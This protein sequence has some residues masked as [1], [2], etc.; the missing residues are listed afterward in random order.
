M[1]GL[2]EPCSVPSCPVVSSGIM[3]VDALTLETG[4]KV[5]VLS[6]V[7]RALWHPIAWHPV[8]SAYITVGPWHVPSNSH[9]PY[10]GGLLPWTYVYWWR[11][12]VH[13]EE[14]RPMGMC[15]FEDNNVLYL[16]S[17]S[18]PFSSRYVFVLQCSHVCPSGSDCS[19][20]GLSSY[21]PKRERNKTHHIKVTSF[22]YKKRKVQAQPRKPLSQQGINSGD[23]VKSVNS[24]WL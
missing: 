1:Q 4:H 23:N 6:W 11:D 14:I 19:L 16:D 24:G 21:G 13:T 18:D 5:P 10:H 17:L 9:C 2:L 12:H 3:W 7:T 22:V 20:L 8:G 15:R